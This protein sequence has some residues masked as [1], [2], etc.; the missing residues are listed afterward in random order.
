MRRVIYSLYIDIPNS[1]LVSHR[2]SKKLFADNYPWLLERQKQ[3]AKTIGVDY[4]HFRASKTFNRYCEWFNVNYPDVS[5]YNIVNFYKIHLLYE[6]S[7]DYDEVLYLDMDVIP[8]TQE[9]FFDVWD[10]SKGIAIKTGYDNQ[11][12][13]PN[14]SKAIDLNHSVRSPFAKYWNTRCMLSEAEVSKQT[15]VFNTGIL[16]AC[17]KHLHQLEYFKNFEETLNAMTE[18]MV[19]EFYPENIR[20]LFGYDNETIWGYKTLMLDV[21]YQELDADWH[22]FM[23]KWSYVTD[24][25]KLIHCISKNFLYVREWCEKNNI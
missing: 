7:K 25:S 1:K 21:P 5:F 19:D 3:Y 15:V 9:S 2:E 16:G 13:N 20:K 17:S 23:D 8:T 22:F 12:D 10:L 6:L 14:F 18:M 4:K 24:T 11:A